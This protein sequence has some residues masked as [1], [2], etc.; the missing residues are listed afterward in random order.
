MLFRSRRLII[1]LALTL[2]I[3]VLLGG[4][5][6]ESTTPQTQAWDLSAASEAGLLDPAPQ[7][8]G[9]TAHGTGIDLGADIYD[10]IVLHDLLAGEDVAISTHPSLKW[11]PTVYGDLVVW[12]DGRN[13]VGNRDIFVYDYAL[14]IEMQVTTDPNDQSAPVIHGDRIVYIDDRNGNEDIYMYDLSTSTETAI[15]DDPARQISPAIYGDIVA[16]MDY[17][18]GTYPDVYMYDISTATESP[19]AIHG[20]YYSPSF[21]GGGY[22]SIYEDK[23]VWFDWRNGNAD[24]FMYD[25]TTDVET[26]ITTDA[27]GQRFPDIY[28]DIIVWEDSRNSPLPF[29]PD[30]EQKDIYMYDLTTETE[31]PV[32]TDAER[33]EK[34]PAIHGDRIVW[35]RGEDVLMYD[36]STDTETVIATGAGVLA[37]PDIHSHRIVWKGPAPVEPT[38]RLLYVPLNWVRSQADFNAEVDTQVG[39]FLDAIPLSACPDRLSVTALNV[40]TQNFNTFTCNGDCGVG[41][42]EPFVDSLGINHA[43]YTAVVGLIDGTP[44]WPTRGCSSGGGHFVWADTA[45]TT[46]TAHELGHQFG[47]ED[48]YCSNPAGSTDCRCND[49]D[50]G[51]CCIRASDGA[52]VCEDVGGDGAATGDLN[53][54]DS[55]LGCDPDGAPCC[56]NATLGTCGGTY[57]E[58]CCFGNQND[59]GGR[60]IMSYANAPDPRAFCDHCVDHLDTVDELNCPDTGW[61]AFQPSPMTN[62][63]VIDVTLLVHKDDTVEERRVT[64]RRGRPSMNYDKG[65]DYRLAVFG[66]QEKLMWSQEFNIYFDYYGPVDAHVDYSSIQYDAFPISRRIPY[67]PTMQE[68][69]LYHGE[70]LIYSRVLNFCNQDGTCDPSETYLTCPAD[71]PLNERDGICLPNEDGVCD[72]DCK[73]GVDPDCGPELIYIKPAVV[74]LGVSEVFS[75]AVRVDAI[76]NLYGVQLALSFDPDVVE[77]VDADPFMPGV[78]IETGSFLTPDVVPRN[79]ASNTEGTIEYQASLQGVKPGVSGSGT[80]AWIEL[81]GVNAGQSPVAFTTVVL[82]D[83]QSVVIEVDRFD[84]VV[85]VQDEAQA[86]FTVVGQVELE[87]R[88]SN[89]G[90]EVCVEGT[91]A[92]T[93]ETG[94]YTLSGVHVGQ[95]VE[96]TH[97]SYLRSARTL[98]DPPATVGGTVTL[99]DVT[100]LGGDVDQDDR[101]Y[102]NDAALVGAAMIVEPV[103][104]PWYRVRDITDDGVVDILDFVAVQF[105]WDTRAPSPWSDVI[106]AH[107]TDAVATRVLSWSGAAPDDVVVKI[108]PETASAEGLGVPIWLDIVVEEVEDLYAFAVKV[109]FDPTV[110]QVRDANPGVTGIQVVPGDF[111]DYEHWLITVNEADNETGLVELA[112]TQT[113]QTPG[114]DGSGVLGSIIFEG[115]SEGTSEVRFEE[116]DLRAIEWPYTQPI[117]SVGQD[118]TVT[119]ASSQRFIYLPLVTRDHP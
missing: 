52:T 4:S 115:I 38:V 96:V 11:S 72:P 101:I 117:P 93:D 83:P 3:C 103:D 106:K 44:C 48:E 104:E 45:R 85:I 12:A 70:N 8:V 90:A 53:W 15:C 59:A 5:P 116:I 47:L 74:T 111:L 1:V 110:L 79:L 57:P 10:D 16:W 73:W 99:P 87:R 107:V 71:C 32:S 29:D 50:S 23:I 108:D 14:G 28:G 2:S 27:L 60:C 51:E 91:C 54:L 20:E 42:I 75:V 66:A 102:N 65:D 63:Q 119:I 25:I 40:V 26:Q 22:I 18:N 88:T 55:D 46:V 89:A 41:S 21:S 92:T 80:L 84:G 62:G 118:G 6:L 109:T 67:D 114:Q 82:S 86:P 36:L 7:S 95:E 98:T 19:V 43:D 69:R 78:Q 76:E 24:V 31:S 56:N 105:N 30:T 49:G 64:L 17:R 77:V 13:G 68:L 9:P 37:D 35:T 34:L 61:L 112:I 33:V 113:G 94:N 58:V 39:F 100:L 97:P 81:H